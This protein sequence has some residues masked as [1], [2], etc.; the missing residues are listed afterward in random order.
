MYR[1]S[2]VAPTLAE[3]MATVPS[4]VY[5]YPPTQEEEDLPELDF[6]FLSQLTRDE[7]DLHDLGD[8]CGASQDD[9]FSGYI[10]D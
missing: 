7:G 3:L 5:P 10:L 4:P 2:G 9:F 1:G 6:D 8:I